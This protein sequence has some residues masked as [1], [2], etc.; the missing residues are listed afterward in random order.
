MVN[1]I[2]T[3]SGTIFVCL[4]IFVPL[5]AVMSD[6]YYFW[7]PPIVMGNIPTISGSELL[8]LDVFHFYG[9]CGFL[10][11]IIY[12]VSGIVGKRHVHREKGEREGIRDIISRSN[13]K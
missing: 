10:C 1:N 12:L 2:R 8:S 11:G 13:N 3:I 4:C 6:S 9:F 7:W 5:V